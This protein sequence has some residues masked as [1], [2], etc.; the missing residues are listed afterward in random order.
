M[1]TPQVALQ[2]IIT[3]QEIPYDDMVALM[4]QIMR[5]EVSPV[6]MAAILSGKRTKK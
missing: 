4:R 1:M 6:L 5:G 2:R 3:H